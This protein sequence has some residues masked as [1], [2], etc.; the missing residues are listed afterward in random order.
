M[1]LQGLQIFV[2]MAGLVVVVGVVNFVLQCV[3]SH[4][5]CIA[6]CV[7]QF[8]HLLAVVEEV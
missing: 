1:P 5:D 6:V 3:A 7:E 8:A 4:G 2:E